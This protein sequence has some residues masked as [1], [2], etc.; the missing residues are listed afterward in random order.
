[1]KFQIFSCLVLYLGV[2]VLLVDGF[3]GLAR[4]GSLSG[5]K[6]TNKSSS[7]KAAGSQL[8][9]ESKQAN[10][11]G[12]VKASKTANRGYISAWGIISIIMLVI[13]GS[14]LVYYVTVFYPLV[15]A[16]RGKYDVMEMTTV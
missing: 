14:V 1:M 2:Y 9:V 5:V 7:R 3:G 8:A 4:A 13:V 6:S 11:G 12:D 10:I 15:C 16:E